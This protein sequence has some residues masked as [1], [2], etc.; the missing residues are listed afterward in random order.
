MII[1]TRLKMCVKFFLLIWSRGVIKRPYRRGMFG[2]I[3]FTGFDVFQHADQNGPA[4]ICISA[5]CILFAN[6]AHAA[7]WLADRASA[8]CSAAI[9]FSK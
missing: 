2:H 9:G 5:G 6:S 8:V 3:L 4:R 7:S 1:E